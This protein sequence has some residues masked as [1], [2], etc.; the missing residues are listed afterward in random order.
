MSNVQNT[1]LS[2]ESSS[3]DELSSDDDIQYSQ[4]CCVCF[5]WLIGDC[6]VMKH[7][8][9]KYHIIHKDCGYVFDK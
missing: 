8:K 7:P 2:D 3:G 1:Y 6:E 9:K 4:K 5:D